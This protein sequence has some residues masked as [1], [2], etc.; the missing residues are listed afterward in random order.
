MPRARSRSL[1]KASPLVAG[2]WQGMDDTPEPV[3]ANAQFVALARNVYIPPRSAGSSYIGRPGTALA[4]TQLGSAGQRTA[5]YIGQFTTQAG[6]EYTVLVLYGE[7][8]TYN[9]STDAWTKVVSAANFATASI[10]IATGGRIRGITFANELVLSDGVNLPFSWDGS[11]G[12]GGLTALTA[13]EVFYGRPWVRA[14]KLSGIKATERD[15]WVWSEEG[16]NNTGYE[17]GGYTN[18]WTVPNPGNERLVAG[19]ASNSA[20]TLFWETSASVILGAT[21]DEWTTGNT[22]PSVSQ[23]LGTQSP[24][25]VLAIDEGVVFVDQGGRPQIIPAGASQPLPLY[26]RCRQALASINRSALQNVM[27]IEDRATET[28]KI[29]YPDASDSYPSKWLVFTRDGG[30]LTLTG[31]ESGYTA[32]VAGMVKNAAGRWVWM[33]AGV[34]DGYIYRH[35]TP[36]DGP[37]SDADGTSTVPIQRELLTMALGTDTTVEKLFDTISVQGFAPTTQTLTI[38]YVTPRA[39]STPQTVSL[40]GF[41][42]AFGSAVWD[43]STFGGDSNDTRARVGILGRGRW[44]QVLAAQATLG[45]QFGI[46][47]IPVMA[48]DEGAEPAIP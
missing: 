44:I 18:A 3:A 46:E 34:D 27:A 12:A 13:A 43:T 33:H 45:E 8:Y 9:W 47:R 31:I 39:S 20:I 40:M 35:G 16:F 1:P 48:F 10:T 5:Q 11:S 21:N 24:D 22:T 2:D 14:S 36:E 41:G 15:T 28:L 26:E 38:S 17:S 7:I 4:G 25:S 30:R 29:G 32:S 23:S 6:T 42:A 37:W 19:V